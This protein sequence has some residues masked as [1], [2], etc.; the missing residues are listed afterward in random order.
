MTSILRLLIAKTA[1]AAIVVLIPAPFTKPKDM[2]I[3]LNHTCGCFGFEARKYESTIPKTKL[4]YHS[5]R[6]GEH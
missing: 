1:M 2:P 4:E 3:G 6:L 5:Y